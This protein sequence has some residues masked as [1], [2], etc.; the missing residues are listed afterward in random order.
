M[1]L[2]ILLHLYLFRG[3]STVSLFR[4]VAQCLELPCCIAVEVLQKSAQKSIPED[5]DVE[6]IM[7]QTFLIHD[8]MKSTKYCCTKVN[9]QA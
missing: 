6:L 9:S 3:C 2:I 5:D 8:W 1:D 4:F 7:A